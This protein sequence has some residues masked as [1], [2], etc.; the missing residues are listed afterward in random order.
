MWCLGICK[1]CWSRLEYLWVCYGLKCLSVLGNVRAI[2]ENR[3][4]HRVV[5]QRYCRKKWLFK[6]MGPAQFVLVGLCVTWLH[7][8]SNDKKYGHRFLTWRWMQKSTTGFCR[9]WV[10]LSE[11][12]LMQFQLV[13]V[14]MCLKSQHSQIEIMCILAHRLEL[15]WSQ[16]KPIC[17][18]FTCFVWVCVGEGV[19]FHFS[20]GTKSFYCCCFF[21]LF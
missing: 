8:R 1:A 21:F 15:K 9:S 19:Y 11:T 10:E 6:R 2:L 13:W 5:W 20:W 14:V 16:D 7:S 17:K 18:V 3:Y 4:H 12:G